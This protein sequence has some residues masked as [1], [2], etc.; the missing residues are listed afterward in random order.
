MSDRLPPKRLRGFEARG[1]IA[2][3]SAVMVLASPIFLSR[4]TIWPGSGLLP[5][6]SEVGAQ[7]PLPQRVRSVKDDAEM[8]LVAAGPFEYGMNQSEVKRIV[9]LLKERMVDFYRTELPKETKTLKAYYIDRHEVTNEQYGRFLK[10]TGHR[11]PLYWKYPQFNGKRQPVVGV[12]WGDAES[13]CRWAGKRLPGEE[14]WEKAA[15]GTDG[16]IWPWGNE[17]DDKKYN[18]RTWANFASVN[19]G[20]FPAGNSPYGVSDMAGNVWEMTSGTWSEGARVMRGGSFLNTNADIRVTVRWAAQDE[21]RGANWL[22]F[23]CVMET[24]HLKQFAREK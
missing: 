16:R 4:V 19:V 5:V 21:D 1:L 9:A 24:V 11:T 14:E 7:G 3:L 12:G 8:I 23:R 18:G 6:P 13:Y 17:S 15:R 20:S 10:E 2:A 22:G